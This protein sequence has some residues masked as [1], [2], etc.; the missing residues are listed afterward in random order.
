VKRLALTV[1]IVTACVLVMILVGC[2][3]PSEQEAPTPAPTAAPTALAVPEF[4]HMTS[5]QRATL[6]ALL[7][8][9]AHVPDRSEMIVWQLWRDGQLDPRNYKPDYP[10][11]P[12][13]AP[14]DANPPDP[15]P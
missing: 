8:L 3:D 1:A 14:I 6:P 5:E 9:L 12:P 11:C 10:A 7:C 15:A 2:G 4:P 13:Y